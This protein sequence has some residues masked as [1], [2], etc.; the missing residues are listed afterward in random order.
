[1]TILAITVFPGPLFPKDVEVTDVSG[2]TV[3][4]AEDALKKA[5]FSVA[6]ESI[7]IADEKIEK[8]LV[9]KTDPKIGTKVKEGT[10][11]QLYESTGKEKTE[12]PDV[13]GE[14]VD[15]A[16]EI[17]EKKGFKQVVVEEVNDNDTESGIVMEQNPSANTELVAKR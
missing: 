9:V 10:E 4:K 1:M 13:T 2:M 17:L 8:G 16:K 12:L 6:S 15:K 3:E 5:G 11:I 7:E 14:K